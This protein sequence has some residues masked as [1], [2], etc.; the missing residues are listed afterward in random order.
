MLIEPRY[1]IVLIQ[2]LRFSESA[3]YI[4]ANLIVNLVI[5]IPGFTLILVFAKVPLVLKGRVGCFVIY[6]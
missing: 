1:Y 3:H 6:T 2:E 5:N 4:T